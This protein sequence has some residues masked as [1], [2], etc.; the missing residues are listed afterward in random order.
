MP[1]SDRENRNPGWAIHEREQRRRLAA[2]PFSEKLQWL[3]EADELVRHLRSQRA[4][5]RATAHRD[6]GSDSDRNG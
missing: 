4:D 3:E 6:R 5:R 1:V 2:L